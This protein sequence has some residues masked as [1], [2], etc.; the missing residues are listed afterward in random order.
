MNI[1]PH[2]GDVTGAGACSTLCGAARC[3]GRGG[4]ATSLQ[5]ETA[6]ARGREVQGVTVQAPHRREV[7]AQESEAAV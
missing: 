1:L 4:V 5:E 2:G 3:G 6:A 7:A